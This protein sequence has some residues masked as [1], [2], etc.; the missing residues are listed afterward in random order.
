MADGFRVN[1]RSLDDTTVVIPKGE[2][3][4]ATRD[5]LRAALERCNGSVVVDLSGVTFLDSSG[6]GVLASQHKRLVNQGGALILREPV[7]VVRHTL[8]VVGLDEWIDV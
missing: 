8:T 7:D 6:I 2:I 3:D 1:V 5:D 4:L